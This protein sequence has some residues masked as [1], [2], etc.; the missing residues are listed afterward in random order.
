MKGTVSS[1][2][3]QE[4]RS[5]LKFRRRREAQAEA[6]ERNRE[7]GMLSRAFR[8][9][10]E[11]YDGPEPQGHN[12]EEANRLLERVAQDPDREAQLYADMKSPQLEREIVRETSYGGFVLA[13]AEYYITGD[14]DL[15]DITLAAMGDEPWKRSLIIS[16]QDEYALQR[17]DGTPAPQLEEII[18]VQKLWAIYGKKG[19]WPAVTQPQEPYRGIELW[20]SPGVEMPA[21]QLWA[22]NIIDNYNAAQK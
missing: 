7:A 8:S 17:P 2:F 5:L 3:R 15:A 13:Q 20:A 16:P 19:T 9:V 12:R 6:E 14:S 18:T 21:L 11:D 4:L 1:A 22:R 10:L